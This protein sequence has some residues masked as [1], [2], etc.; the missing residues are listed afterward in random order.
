METTNSTEEIQYQQALKKVKRIKGFY[1]HLMVYI[2]INVMILLL[3]FFN[4]ERSQDFWQWQ[5]FGMAIFWG[6]GIV[7]HA[8][9]VFLPTLL[10]SN[11]W[12]QRKI[13]ELMEKD[14]NKKWE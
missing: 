1:I 12:E 13:N 5:T 7:S 8:M 2:V 10:L 4:N 14:R 3:Q 9:S 11:D 6:I